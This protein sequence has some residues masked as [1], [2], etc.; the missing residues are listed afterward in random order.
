MKWITRIFACWSLLS[1]LVMANPANE[2]FIYDA[3]RVR[4]WIPD[5]ATLPVARGILFLGN[6]AGADN[7]DSA[8]NPKLQDWA[9]R[10]G[11]VL[12]GTRAGNLGEDD[13]WRPFMSDVNRVIHA[14]G[15]RELHHAPILYWGHSM[16][17]QQ[18]YGMA[19][20]I[21]DRMIA[22]I[23]N[24]GANY[25]REAGSDPWNV[26]ALMIAGGNDSELRRTNIHNL[27]AEG[28]AQGAPWA[29]LE[30]FRVGHGL[31][32]S[33]HIAFGFF[34]DILAQRYPQNPDNVPTVS[35]PP[36]LQPMDLNQ[37]WLVKTGHEEW[38]TGFVEIFPQQGYRGN[39]LD[40]GWVPSRRTA[41]LYR[42]LASYTNPNRDVGRNQGKHVVHH[43]PFRPIGTFGGETATLSRFHPGQ[44]VPYSFE[45]IGNPQWTEI[46]IYSY[47]VLIHTLPASPET[48]F[49]VEFTL[50]P[51]WPS[52]AVHMVM[53][54]DNGE[55]RTSLIH[56]LTPTHDSTR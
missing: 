11:F 31:G 29:W 37:G 20:R 32:N 38:A 34:E 12:M 35:G 51:E 6:G 17:G 48:R 28:R 53:E 26:P 4:A 30:E 9:L 54:L 21:P 55:K 40:H 18:A 49:E 15:R 56:F 33:M 2:P 50:N 42:A 45:L 19:R 8:H 24:K 36:T 22:F 39:P 1:S 3:N 16:G 44:T 5:E 7:K 23:V 52:H 43:L 47:D 25:V 41:F 14:S 13:A 46:R 10:R 27:Y